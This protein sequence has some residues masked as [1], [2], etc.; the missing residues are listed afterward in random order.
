MSLIVKHFLSYF[1][2]NK[3]NTA[4]ICILIFITSFMYFFVQCSIDQNLSALRT[5]SVLS[6]TDTE[7]MTALQSNSVLSLVFLFALALITVFVFYLFYRKKFELE[8]RNTGL[9]LALGFTRGTVTRI[10]MLISAAIGFVF[11]LLGML[12]GYYFS[13]ILLENYQNSLHIDSLSRGL[14]PHSFFMGVILLSGIIS[15]SAVLASRTYTKA[16]T[17]ELLSGQTKEMENDLI[18]RI[19]EKASTVFISKYSFSSRLALRKPFNLLL[20]FLSVLIFLVLILTSFSLNLSSSKVY[21]V[22]S[23]GR[24]FGY[25]VELDALSTVQYD[26]AEYYCAESANVFSGAQELGEFTVTAIDNNCSLFR[27]LADGQAVSLSGN[28]AAVSLRTAEVLGVKTGGSISVQHNETTNA[29]TVKVVA[30]NA[31]MNNV[32]VNRDYWNALLQNPPGSYN[33]LWIKELPP[34]LSNAYTMTYEAYLA[35]LDDANV[36]NRISAVINQAL[37]C[38]FGLL[39]IFLVLLLNFQDNTMNFVYLKKLGYLRSEIC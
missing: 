17:A 16:E 2:R 28:E 8:R 37:G 13:Y 31:A 21:D 4:V 5:K 35:K 39:L 23:A 18:N 20:I 24:T 36:S 34:E 3:A 15:L 29:F 30:D 1:W 14:A 10:Y 22:L 19:A 27:L 25:E 7:L 12:V 33:G 38:V 32:Y 11:S 26:A 9:L 6:E